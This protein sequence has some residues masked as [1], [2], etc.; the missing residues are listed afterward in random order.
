MNWLGLLALAGTAIH[1]AYHLYHQRPWDLLWAC[2]LA[3][4]LIGI[5]CIFDWPACVGVGVM[6]L[7]VGVPM[8]IISLATGEEFAPTSLL[9][10]VGGLT[11]G[12]IYVAE[13]GMW[14][15]AWWQ[16]LIA[17]IVLQRVCRWVT[18]ADANVNLAVAVPKGW[19]SWFPSYIWY[20]L[21]MTLVFAMVFVSTELALRWMWGANP[22]PP[23]ASG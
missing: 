15:G 6:W 1:W 7:S 2:H 18:P 14:P 5:G 23:E 20:W 10:H 13:R 11:V 16:A 21:L 12:L 4:V 22:H 19:E 17:L 8:W 9:T 3:A